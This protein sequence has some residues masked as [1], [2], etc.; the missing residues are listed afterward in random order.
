MHAYL[1]DKS[2]TSNARSEA[3]SL[4]LDQRLFDIQQSLTKTHHA[5][6]SQKSAV[7]CILDSLSRDRTEVLCLDGQPPLPQLPSDDD[8]LKARA[9][10]G[11]TEDQAHLS[12]TQQFLSKK[13]C[14]ERSHQSESA[15]Q[16]CNVPLLRFFQVSC[17]LVLRLYLRLRRTFTLRFTAPTNDFHSLVYLLS[18]LTKQVYLVISRRFFTEPYI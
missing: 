7:N 2:R 18:S 12:S 17:V 5:V 14:Y 10:T 6:I 11:A 13:A 1:I 3:L 15:L 8:Y 4:S 16:W 9:N